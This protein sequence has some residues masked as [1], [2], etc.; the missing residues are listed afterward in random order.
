[1]KCVVV[2]C[3]VEAHAVIQ[4]RLWGKCAWSVADDFG[5]LP[6]LQMIVDVFDGMAEL[7]LEVRFYIDLVDGFDR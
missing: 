1:M 6:H 7:P 4:Q 2:T 3:L 5:G